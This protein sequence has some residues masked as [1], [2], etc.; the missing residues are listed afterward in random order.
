MRT[1][2]IHRSSTIL[3][4]LLL[5]AAAASAQTVRNIA[6]PVK[7]TDDAVNVFLAKQWARLGWSSFSGTLAGCNYVISVPAPAVSFTPG[8][9][10]LHL[11][12]DVTS[13]NCGGPWHV[14]LSPIIA[15]PSGQLT[16]AQVKI[17]LVDLY[18]LIDAL[19]IPAWVK[20]ALDRELGERWG[21]PG[22][23][24]NLDAFPASLLEG[25]TSHWFDQRSVNLYEVNPFELAWQVEDGFLT[26]L[27]SVNI[28]AGQGSTVAPDFKARL[29]P[30]DST[31]WIDLWSNIKANVS[32]VRI[33]TLG[34]TSLYSVS[35]NVYTIKYHGDPVN[36]WIMINLHG[37]K[38][39]VG[40]IYIAWILFEID[41][42]FYSREYKLPTT[43][44]G[45][46]SS[47]G[48]YN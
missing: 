13:S 20:D 1:K 36:E 8:Y 27:P 18:D 16:T 47:T 4:V 28:K 26:L 44:S 11:V 12:V 15:L 17:W 38:I 33:F 46:V 42:T 24:D 34:G 31:D 23:A 9:G 30:W 45:W 14:D 6:V 21:I 19:P 41:Q 37:K 35:P 39:G 29:W 7:L 3:L 43:V 40:P 32:S 25:L 2:R 22:L 10:S 5:L 48:G